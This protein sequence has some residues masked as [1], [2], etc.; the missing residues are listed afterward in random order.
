MLQRTK[1]YS[2]VKI[3]RITNN[4]KVQEK[5]KLTATILTFKST[6]SIPPPSFHK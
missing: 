3:K 4:K 2:E 5:T 1:N 6:S